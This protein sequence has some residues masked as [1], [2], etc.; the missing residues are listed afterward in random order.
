M[1]NILAK[2]VGHVEHTIPKA[3]LTDT[4]VNKAMVKFFEKIYD[5][6]KQWIDFDIVKCVVFAGPGN[7]KNEFSKWLETAA[8]QKSDSDTEKERNHALCRYYEHP[9]SRSGRDYG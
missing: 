5:G 1:G 7:T 4:S 8:M 3:K 2:R 6:V 9:Q